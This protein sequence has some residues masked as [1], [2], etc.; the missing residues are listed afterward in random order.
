M[1]VS[2]ADGDR[3]G[4]VFDVDLRLEKVL[5]ITQTATMTLSADCFNVTNENTVLQRQNKLG[6]YNAD[7]WF[8]A[9]RQRQLGARD[10]QPADLPVRRS[11]RVLRDS[12]SVF[13]PPGMIFPA[14][15]FWSE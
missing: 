9:A 6:S 12:S 11:D 1:V 2:P 7:R 5:V 15:F 13:S 4:S 14:A 10:H 3:Y 8:H